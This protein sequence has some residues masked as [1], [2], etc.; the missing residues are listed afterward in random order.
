MR[1]RSGRIGASQAASGI[2]DHDD[3]FVCLFQ[4]PG[5]DNLR[6]APLVD[7]Q[8][9]CVKFGLDALAYRGV[10]IEQ[11]VGGSPRLQFTSASCSELSSAA[12]A[13]GKHHG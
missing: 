9:V 1:L 11:P 4:L 7:D 8:P 3:G 2:F 10:Q 6:H 13:F 5:R 12:I